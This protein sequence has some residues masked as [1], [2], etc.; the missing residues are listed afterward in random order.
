M[1]EEGEVALVEVA[2]GEE[3]LEEVVSVEVVVERSLARR[4]ASPAWQAAD[5]GE[6]A[7]R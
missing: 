7:R 1:G 4:A 2:L 3:A 5:Q 6:E